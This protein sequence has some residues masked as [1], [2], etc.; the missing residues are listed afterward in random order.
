MKINNI[1]SQQLEL[2]FPY[3]LAIYARLLALDSPVTV[4]CAMFIEEIIL[5]G[6]KSYAN[7]TVISGWDKDFNAITGLNGS[8]KS[9]ILDA[10]CFVLGIDNLRQVRA[11][12]LN[13][14]VYKR[15]Q[16][17][18][19]KATV[20][21]VFNN[22]DKSKSP[23]GYT[24]SPKI[25]VTRQVVIG[26][27]NKYL[28]N[29][30][31]VTQKNI[32]SLFQ[33]VQ[34]NINNPHFLIMQGQ[35]T[36]V[37][38][39]KSAEI[40]SLVE[41]AAGT[42]MYEDRKEKA[43]SS[44]DKKERKLQEINTMLDNVIRPKL[45][46]LKTERAS[47]FEYQRMENELEGLKALMHEYE[48]LE[49][50]HEIM[51]LSQQKEQ[52]EVELKESKHFFTQL[53]EQIAQLQSE[54][55]QKAK[56][57]QKS[58]QLFQ[59]ETEITEKSNDSVRIAKVIENCKK[60]I[61]GEELRAVKLNGK[62]NA[63]LKM[64]REKRDSEQTLVVCIEEEKQK[65]EKLK[66]RIN[67]SS[68]ADTKTSISQSIESTRS[69]I[70]Q[71]KENI[72]SI[73]K[74]L[75]RLKKKDVDLGQVEKEIA[76][77][78]LFLSKYKTSIDTLQTLTLEKENL[79]NEKISLKNSQ[80]VNEQKL[81]NLK[82]Q[83]YS[84]EFKYESSKEFDHSKVYGRFASL[85]SL[86]DSKYSSALEVCAGGKLYNVV[87]ADQHAANHILERNKFQRRITFIPLNKIS[88]FVIPQAKVDRIK[89]S[90]DGFVELASN[91]VSYDKS[92]KSAV[93]YVLGKCFVCSN[94]E[95]AK[96]IAFDQKFRAITLDGDIYSPSGTLTGGSR[97]NK[98]YKGAA[99]EES[100]S[101]FNYLSLNASIVES[102]QRMRKIN[103]EL[104]KLDNE[105]GSMQSL[106]K[107]LSAKKENI[108]YLKK[109]LVE[110]ANC[111]DEKER[112]QLALSVEQEKLTQQEQELQHYSN[113]SLDDIL[114]TDRKSI[115]ELE[116]SFSKNTSTLQHLRIELARL[117]E[118]IADIKASLARSEKEIS[119]QQSGLEQK[120]K[121]LNELDKTLSEL[122]RVFNQEMREYEKHEKEISLLKDSCDKLKQQQTECER[123]SSDLQR[124]LDAIS[125]RR[126][127][128][129]ENFR[130]LSKPASISTPALTKNDYENICS[131]CS[132]LAKELE[133]MS[134]DPQE[135]GIMEVIDS[136]EKKEHKLSEM[137][138]TVLKDKAK[139]SQT[140]V[141]LNNYKKKT[142]SQ[143]ISRVDADFCDIFSKL[144]PGKSVA[145]FQKVNTKSSTQS[146]I[147]QLHSEEVIDGL[148]IKISLDAGKTFK[149]SLTELSGGQRSLVALS[150]ILALLKYSPA[151]VYILDEIDAALDLSHTQNIGLLL[152]DGIFSGSQF[153]VV[154]LKDGMFSNAN[155]LFRT[156]FKDG[157][158]F[159]EHMANK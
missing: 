69:S 119:E 80:R 15:G 52:A 50:E 90:Y 144:L 63:N 58:D 68:Q 156:H 113:S 154:S 51:Q 42:K 56:A 4:D 122:R 118:E 126:K 115:A 18:I 98:N 99:S 81:A 92:I 32:D 39:M 43:L 73:A 134:I 147:E 11:T 111:M 10:I 129:K 124:Q 9:N 38:N 127:E 139:I 140:I 41:E 19:T 128:T 3:K 74:K 29:G 40:L 151:P 107:E 109:Q 87:V 157:I 137:L 71:S 23:I 67:F 85:V 141:K 97:R 106:T 26:G 135:K 108:V 146:N 116:Q 125:S 142:L 95:T 153:I 77:E 28:V 49:M 21:I 27:K 130:K 150:L 31:V 66:E 149:N 47:Y 155:V 138:Q 132:V 158:S 46:Q 36:N 61:D 37:L 131:K 25:T 121:S 100:L 117:D 70:C 105:I 5:D 1:I 91:L 82:S 6:F 120:T 94:K 143:T 45:A 101:P 112:L 136:L 55:Q 53:K 93:D 152:K 54:I 16:T 133:K 12:T 79:T 30:H 59:L 89:S 86:V 159:A 20:S 123:Q 102:E 24:D 96:K 44:M 13:D 145:K 110:I 17:G 2:F 76:S 64:Q 104:T 148:E 78:E 84:L 8:G 88:P 83:Y 14:L 62:M 72:S 34:L 103:N 57:C 22:Q 114:E 75:A 65:L 60:T 33:S 7:R 48:Y 35:I